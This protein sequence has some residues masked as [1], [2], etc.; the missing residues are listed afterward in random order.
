MYFHICI[1]TQIRIYVSITV[2]TYIDICVFVHM[3]II[4]MY[5]QRYRYMYVYIY[6]IYINMHRGMYMLK[7]SESPTNPRAILQPSL[8][9]KEAEINTRVIPAINGEL[10]KWACVGLGSHKNVTNLQVGELAEGIILRLPTMLQ[11]AL[12]LSWMEYVASGSGCGLSS[13]RMG[14]FK[15][16]SPNNIHDKYSRAL[17]SKT[18]SRRNPNLQKQPNRMPADIIL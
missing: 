10:Q 13:Y 14:I 15:N 18:P 5:F 11:A 6:S 16:Q 2:Y 9:P 17:F 7:F 3:N 8:N 1:H 4:H 12:C